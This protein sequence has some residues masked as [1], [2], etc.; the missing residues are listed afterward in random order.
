MP[1]SIIHAQERTEGCQKVWGKI[2]DRRV[3]FGGECAREKLVNVLEVEVKK[4][5]LFKLNAEGVHH[6]ASFPTS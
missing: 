6:P 4:R 2:R 5:D 1:R 3:E